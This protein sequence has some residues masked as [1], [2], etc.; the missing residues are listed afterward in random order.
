MSRANSLLLVSLLLLTACSPASY[1]CTD[2][3]GCLEIPP[4]APFLV[5]VLT[6]F[7]G[8]Y[9]EAGTAMLASIE[10]AMEESGDLA[11]HKIELVWEEADCSE[12]S[13]RIGATRLALTPNL[14]AVI[15]PSCPAAAP[16][17][18]PILADAGLP[19]LAPHPNGGAAFRRLA[20][21]I[22]NIAIQQPDGTIILPRTA[23]Q[24]ALE[25]H[26]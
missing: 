5:G 22:Q 3:L 13:A 9:A 15:G 10:S 26:P 8:P 14:V 21:A 1:A 19:L 25:T 18:R 23:L 6:T 24:Q 2:P 20:E 16:Y 17:A 7:S 11:G 4:N 12:D